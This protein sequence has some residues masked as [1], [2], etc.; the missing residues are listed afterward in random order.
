MH[1]KKHPKDLENT[2]IEHFLNY[3]ATHRKVSAATQNQAL[4]ALV[5]MYRYVLNRE[6]EGCCRRPTPVFTML[7]SYISLAMLG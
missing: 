6:I 2:E 7:I 4:C 1:N 5:F 3:L